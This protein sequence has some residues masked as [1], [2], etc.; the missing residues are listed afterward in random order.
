MS[1]LEAIAVGVPTLVTPF[2][3]GRSLAASGAVLE[4]D[5]ALDDIAAGLQRLGSP[6]A[7]S[8]GARGAEIARTT[9]SW[10]AVA[11]SWLAQVVALKGSAA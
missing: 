5:W 11:S 1:V 4:T 3:M 10:R 6:E 9:F 7:A 8:V 2:A